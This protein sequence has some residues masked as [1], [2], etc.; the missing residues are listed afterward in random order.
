MLLNL[1]NIVS[2][3][4]CSL[5]DTVQNLPIDTVYIQ[6]QRLEFCQLGRVKI[7][8]NNAATSQNLQQSLL[9]NAVFLK[10]YGVS[11]S[12]TIS[13]RGA[14]AA[15]TQVLWNGLP[16]NNPMLGMTDFN[17]ISTF[18]LQE[19][20]LIEGGNAALFGSGSV[21]GTVFLRNKVKFGEGFHALASY[22]RAQFNN[23]GFAANLQY[24]G[25]SHFIQATWAQLNHQNTFNF[26]DPISLEN[27]T[28]KNANLFQNTFRTVYGYKRKNHELKAVL[29]MVQNERGLGQQLGS[30]MLF[31]IQKDE[32][33]RS[34]IEHQ[35]NSGKWLFVNRLGFVRD[36]IKYYE[37][38][39][40]ADSSIAKTPY[41]QSEIYKNWLGV[42]WLLGF[43]AQQQNAYSIN[44]NVLNVKRL[45]TSAFA[46]AMFKVQ[47]A[48]INLNVRHEFYEHLPTFGFSAVVPVKQAFNI[49][50]NLHSTFR[51]PTLNDLFWKTNAIETTKPEKGWGMELGIVKPFVFKNMEASV[52]LTGYYRELNQPIIWVPNGWS[53]I[54]TNFHKGQYAGIQWNA[55]V[56]QVVKATKISI[57]TGG[58]YVHAQVQK[59]PESTQYAQIFIPD[60]MGFLSVAMDR[61]KWALKLEIQHTGNRFTQT[62]NQA[63]LPGYRLIHAAWVWKSMEIMSLK[64]KEK[65]KAEISLEGRNLGNVQYQ[66]MPGRPMPGRT[67]GIYLNI[68]I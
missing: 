61:K 48:D 15:Q 23:Q 52:E 68:T 40:K 39:A 19:A 65:L 54:A 8:F 10:Q 11:G 37:N 33:L 5:S 12:S 43:D 41:F 56:S 45:Y 30:T 35:Y 13:R 53:W 1:L 18:G 17:N 2:T 6:S 4:C 46:S 25:K 38:T 64:N 62:D 36:V 44:Y 28:A 22:Q 3:I 24:S 9:S 14:D 59:Q 47:T 31:G 58:E 20:F 51:R 49:K 55:K 63:W 32:N 57:V 42:R 21:G 60:F 29:E 16:V 66:N 50:A 26:Q 27:R 34:V 67:I 7:D